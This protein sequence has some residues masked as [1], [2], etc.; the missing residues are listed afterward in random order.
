[1]WKFIK[2]TIALAS[3][4]AAGFG[5]KKA[6]ATPAGQRAVTAGAQTAQRAQAAAKEAY[7]KGVE[8]RQQRSR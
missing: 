2:G 4:V 3:I 5:I 6:A 8:R 1:M 7:L